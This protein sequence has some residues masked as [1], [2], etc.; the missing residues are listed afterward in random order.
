MMRFRVV[1]S[2]DIYRVSRFDGSYHNA[3]INVYDSVISKHSTHTLSYYCSEIF[4]SGRNKRAYTTPSFGVPFLSNSDAASQNPFTSCKYS[5]MKYGYDENALLKGGM[6]LTGRVGAIGQTSIVPEY[7]ESH[8]AMG[9]DNIIRIVV[10]KDS[11][12]TNG[13]I[14]AYLASRIGYL[15]FWKH[16]TGGV[17]PFITDAMVGQLPIP[18]LS[19]LTQVKAGTLVRKS[20]N[21]RTE[22]VNILESAKNLMYSY[23]GI[24][25]ISVDEYDFYGP[26]VQNRKVSCFTISKKSINEVSINAFNHSERIRKLKQRLS[27][28]VKIR[29][30]ISCLTDEGIF[31]TGSFPRVEVKPANGVELINQRDIFDSVIRGKYISKRGVKLD[32]LLSKDEVIIAG[33]GTLGE[34]ETFCR[35]V[36]ANSY[37]AGKLISGEFLR[38]KCN[39]EVP[40][41]YLYLWLSSEYGFRL[42]RNTQAGTKLCR[43]IPKLL[44]QLPVPELR[45]S[46]MIA[47]DSMVKE[48]QE[49]FAQA[50][51]AELEAISLVES[52]IEKWNN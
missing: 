17:Q 43:P 33:V 11:P 16:A 9:S 3:E 32:N 47:I 49:K 18:D 34:S 12:Y 13:L 2:K 41:G 14:Y 42:I 26:S 51:L 31:T 5:S 48:A 52:E 28:A 7:W 40:S 8:K 37:L 45:C 50:S 36:Y 27:S 29:T 38:M 1:N 10:S 35:C 46:E 15:S 6:I 21:L 4:T 39:N 23:L 30:L 44:E 22:A 25:S 24:G 20:C 19:E